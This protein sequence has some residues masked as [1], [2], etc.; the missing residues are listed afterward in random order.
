MW[1]SAMLMGGMGGGGGGG[2]SNFF[3]NLDQGSMAKTYRNIMWI[4]LLIHLGLSIGLIVV[5]G[6]TGVYELIACLILFWANAQANFCCMIMYIL[7]CMIGLLQMVSSGGLVLQRDDINSDTVLFVLSWVFILF[8]IVAL[9][10]AFYTYREY[11]ALQ[12]GQ[13]GMMGGMGGRAAPA[14]AANGQNQ[15]DGNYQRIGNISVSSNLI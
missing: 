10:A 11:K 1:L 9:T 7:R 13:G 6:W 5:A 8:Y 3:T 2:R 12:T 14:P 15:A 4:I